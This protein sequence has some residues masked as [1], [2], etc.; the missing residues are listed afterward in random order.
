MKVTFSDPGLYGVFT[1]EMIGQFSDGYWEN[2]VKFR[3][4]YNLYKLS[5][6]FSGKHEASTL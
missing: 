2:S 6:T 5:E 4:D 1:G 3:K